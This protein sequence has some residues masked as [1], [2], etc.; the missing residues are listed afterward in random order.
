MPALPPSALGGQC[1]F[2]CGTTIGLLN[3]GNARSVR[4]VCGPCNGARRVLDGQSRGNPAVRAKLNDL[5]KNQQSEYK[6]KVRCA[7]IVPAHLAIA[8]GSVDQVTTRGERREVLGTLTSSV[9]ASISVADKDGVMWPD[10]GQWCYLKR[11]RE[12]LTDDEALAQWRQAEA[13]YPAHCR[14]GSGAGLRLAYQ[15]IPRTDGIQA[16]G[17]KRSLSAMSSVDNQAEFEAAARMISTAGIGRSL[18]DADFAEV[19]GAAFRPNSALSGDSV[20]TQ[21][22][23]LL[24][25]RGMADISLS[26]SEL[27]ANPAGSAAGAGAPR[28]L[29]QTPSDPPPPVAS[30]RTD[31]TCCHCRY[32]EDVELATPDF[33][34]PSISRVGFHNIYVSHTV[35]RQSFCLHVWYFSWQVLQ[36]GCLVRCVFC[37]L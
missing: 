22:S 15:D 28:P 12:N 26:F 16:R 30:A 17:I 6:R 11:T 1:W 27:S 24:Q 10:V 36:C 25:P 2:E 35:F 9:E 18:T 21:Q 20:M 4:M 5:K 8:D 23:A 13:T 3:I 29:A 32:L 34:L 14:R 33:I 19:G 31:S 7:R 37:C